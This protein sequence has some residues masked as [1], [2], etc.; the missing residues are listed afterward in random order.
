MIIMCEHVDK[1]FWMRRYYCLTIIKV[2]IWEKRDMKIYILF[3][4]S[5]Y[6]EIFS[7]ICRSRIPQI[8][9]LKVFGRYLQLENTFNYLDKWYNVNIFT[10]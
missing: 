10:F 2:H 9:H 8:I 1:E 3:N 7:I 6:W 4:F 5:L